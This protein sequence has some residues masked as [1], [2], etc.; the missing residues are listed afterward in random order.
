MRKLLDALRAAAL[1]FLGINALALMPGD[2]AYQQIGD[3]LLAVHRIFGDASRVKMGANVI[4]NDALINTSSGTV[5]LE[6]FAFCGHGV[7]ILTGHHDYRRKDYERQAGVPQQGNDIV[8]GQGVWLGSNVTVLGPCNIGRDA[9]IAAGAVVSGP[10]D[11]GWIY[12]GV[13]ARPVK[14]IDFAGDPT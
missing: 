1:R 6:D 5:T 11:A 2:T 13:P 7:S 14:P 8:I 12:A 4:L 9:V 10:V 3:R